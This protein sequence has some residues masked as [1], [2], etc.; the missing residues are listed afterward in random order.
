MH[1]NGKT[2]VSA[3]GTLLAEP[4]PSPSVPIMVVDTDAPAPQPATGRKLTASMGA[5]IDAQLLAARVAIDTVL[6]DPDM[7]AALALYGYDAE[8]I[9]AGQALYERALALHRQ[10]QAG[11]GERYTATDARDAAQ[12][13]AH[14]VY[15]RH[16]A[17]ARVALR[18]ERGPAQALGLA[19][20]RERSCAGWLGQAQQFY[21]NALSNSAIGRKLASFGATQPQLIQ[22]QQLVAAVAV[23]LMA[24]QATKESALALTKQRNAALDAMGAWMRDFRAIARV[25]LGA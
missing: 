2:P 17:I 20:S 9:R 22:A 10:Q 5:S 6:G 18:G 16:L 23:K 14:A 11:Y 19:R 3:N 24:Q 25:A 21:A 13:Q 12:A 15:I 4:L 8:H 1:R 7:Q